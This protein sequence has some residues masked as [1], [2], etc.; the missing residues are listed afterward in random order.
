MLQFACVAIHRHIILLGFMGSGKTTIGRLLADRLGRS[1][2]D[3]DDRI[4]SAAGKT[5]AEIFTSDGEAAFR[6]LEG[7]CLSRILSE[8]REPLVI[9]LGGGTFVRQ[10]NRAAIA[11]AS[12][13][14]VFLECDLATLRERVAGFEHRPLTRDPA[15]FAQLYEER[16]PAYR[17]AVH[18]VGTGSGTPEDAAAA[19]AALLAQ[20]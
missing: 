8:E 4:E 19:I 15:A 18:I 9:G 7:E 6:Q 17:E 14:T 5:I 2:V 13:I 16:L 10:H 3:L 20:G 12:G 11:R 1:F